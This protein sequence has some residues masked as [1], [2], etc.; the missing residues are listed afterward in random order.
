[1]GQIKKITI[2]VAHSDIVNVLSELIQLECIEPTKPYIKLD[3]PE[4]SD[5][6]RREVM[7][8]EPYDASLDSIE[9]LATQYTYIL[10]GW[11]NFTFE[12]ELIAMLSSYAC[13]W[14]ITEPDNND[15]DAV[16]LLLKHPQFFGKMR[17]GGRRVFEP[18]AKIHSQR[19]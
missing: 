8:M 13:A 7:E 4:L 15:P 14:E 19:I 9:L 10:T 3:P 18:L 1:M 11:V 6:L 2:I 16:P 5:L 12:P 17:S